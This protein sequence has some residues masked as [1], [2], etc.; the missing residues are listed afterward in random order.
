MM[1][2][3]YFWMKKAKHKKFLSR[4]ISELTEEEYGCIR[5]RG[6]IIPRE[7]KEKKKSNSREKQSTEI[8]YYKQ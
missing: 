4:L 2:K 1:L 8:Y 7:S 6:Y 5:F 3:L